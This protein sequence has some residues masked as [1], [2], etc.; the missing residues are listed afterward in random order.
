MIT[1]QD[2][3]ERRR[4]GVRNPAFLGAPSAAIPSNDLGPCYGCGG[5]VRSTMAKSTHGWLTFK[6]ARYPSRLE[7]TEWLWATAQMRASGA[8]EG[9]IYLSARVSRNRTAVVILDRDGGL[10]AHAVDEPKIAWTVAVT[11]RTSGRLSGWPAG[12][13]PQHRAA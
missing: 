12:D 13:P 3:G 7:G 8:E 9:W 1:G 5:Q 11:K 10:L 4:R 6:S 2:V